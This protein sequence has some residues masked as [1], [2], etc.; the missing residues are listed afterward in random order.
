MN[1]SYDTFTKSQTATG[2]R[3]FSYGSFLKSRELQPTSFGQQAIQTFPSTM[4]SLAELQIDLFSLK[5]NPE[6]AIGDYWNGVKESVI[7]AGESLRKVFTNDTNTIPS[8]SERI[9]AGFSA[10]ARIG[11]AIISPITSLFSAAN[12][13]PIL[14]TVSKLVA[15][16]LVVAGEVAPKISDKIVDELPIPQG[17]KDNIKPGLGELFA[18][19][20][21]IVLGKAV[22]IGAKKLELTKRFGEKDAETIVNKAQDL[23]EE[24][25]A[26]VQETSP[27]VVPA[28]N[29]AVKNLSYEAF[30]TEVPKT[31]TYIY[32]TK[33]IADIQTSV[34]EI[35]AIPSEKRTAMDNTT[36]YNN[37]RFLEKQK[38][39]EKI[40]TSGQVPNTRAQTLEQAAI[41]K[42]LT[43]GLGE[44]PTHNKIDMTEQANSALDFINKSPDEALKIAKGEQ[45]SP[46]HILPEAVYTAMEIKAIKDGDVNTILELSKSNVP[47]AAGQALRALDSTDPNSPVQII[48]DLQQ[49]RETK[50]IK[51][52]PKVV[53]EIRKTVGSMASKRPTWEEFI[54]EITCNY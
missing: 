31:E 51:T 29:I 28:E 11:G 6:K 5:S 47:T 7:S 44:L 38:S 49:A 4:S 17:A 46:G 16:P 48:R 41:V 34:N 22:D 25:R 50:N 30:K 14:G 54:K 45:L 40:G 43:D 20:T 12:D 9:G 42:K 32:S 27:R 8:V 18:L 1:L 35:G 21:Q 36:L 52:K 24:R 39:L 15:L 19:A 10:T 13:V 3:D 33:E 2:G 53:E 23:A 26:Q 37:E